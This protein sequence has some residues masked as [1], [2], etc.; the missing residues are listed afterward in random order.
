MPVLIPILHKFREYTTYAVAVFFLLPMFL[1]SYLIGLWSLTCLILVFAQLKQIRR[2]NVLDSLFY[3]SPFFLILIFIQIH[4]GGGELILE[5]QM[6]FVVFPICIFLSN[7][8]ITRS[9]LKKLTWIFVIG[10]CLL[11]IRGILLYLFVGPHFPYTSQHDFIYRYRA[12][13]NANTGI[14]PT[15]ACLYFGFAIILVLLRIKEFTKQKRILILMIVFLLLNMFLLSAKMPMLATAIILGILF[16]RKQFLGTKGSRKNILVI[17]TGLTIVILGLLF[18]TRWGEF[19]TGLRSDTANAK[20]NTLDVRRMI[21]QCDIELAAKYF[22]IGAGPQHL[23]T[24]LNQCYYQF[25]GSALERN[26]FNTHNQYFDYLLS[27][28]VTGLVLLL[29]VMLVPLYNA[30]RSKDPVLVSFILLIMLCMLTE[31]ILS[32]QAGI[33]FYALFNALLLNRKMHTDI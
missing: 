12:E 6:S 9:E 29:L 26:K 23:Q 18:F 11:A 15:Y 14:N 8:R 3:I 30:I 31:N 33:V 5:R 1:V 7:F 17:G 28:G 13:F 20:E 25:E 32:R 4:G 10:C 27:Y 21:T 2:R 24:K 16:I 19:I 22:A